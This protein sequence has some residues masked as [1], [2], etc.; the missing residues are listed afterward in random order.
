MAYREIQTPDKPDG[1]AVQNIN[2]CQ[3]EADFAINQVSGW[4][5]QSFPL[6]LLQHEK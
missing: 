4:L 1:S 2:F 6:Y 5:G 3:T